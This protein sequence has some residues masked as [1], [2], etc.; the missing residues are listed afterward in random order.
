LILLGDVS[1]AVTLLRSRPQELFVR[2]RPL[3][4]SAAAALV[5]GL[6]GPAVAATS[7]PAAVRPAAGT[8]TSGLTLLALALAG[9]DVR[10]GSVALVSD[11]VSG[12]PAAKV[13]VTPVRADG[14]AYGEQTVT[15]ADSPAS[16]PSF[17]SSATLPAAL[18]TVASV[19]SPVFNVSSSTA[20]GASSKA[21]AAS[22]GSAKVLGLPVTLNGT[23]DVTS[24]VDGTNAVGTKTVSVKNLALPS[25]ADLLAALGLDLKAVPIKTLTDLLAGLGLTNTAVLT[26]QA[27]LNDAQAALG[28]S[29]NDAQAA[30]DQQQA[31]VDAAKAQLAAALTALDAAKVQSTQRQQALAAAQAKA[32]QADQ[33]KVAAQTAYDSANSSIATAAGGLPGS[34][35]FNAYVLAN[36]AAAATLQAATDTYNNSSA[37]AATAAA[38][39]ASAT[40]AAQAATAALNAAQAAVNTAQALVT[41]LSAVLTTLLNT[42]NSLLSQLASQINALL[43]AVTAVLDGTPLVSVDS[44]TVQTQALAKSASAGGQSSKVVGGEIQGVHVLGTDVLENVLGNS[45]INVLDLTGSTLSQVTSK[46]DALTGILSSVLSAVPGLS[47][48]A[49]K[50][51][52]LTKSTS[53]SIANGFGTAQNTVKALSVTIPAIT[54]PAALALPNAASLPAISGAPNLAGALGIAAVGDLTSQAMTLSVGTLS[55]RASF[56]PAGTTAPGA[57]GPP[58]ATTGLPAGVAVLGLLLLGF[59]LVLRRRLT[60]GV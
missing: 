10:V 38:A 42:L 41:S 1:A 4:A 13:V 12:S 54:L 53:T 23:V 2:I 59:G 16:I 29:L 25:I 34:A 46:L 51:Q 33:A 24:L 47:I 26:A 32:T 8:A 28:A 45:K 7:A 60:A 14:K 6:A 22:L 3:A 20:K 17:D 5:L 58:L 52:L 35:L 48:P 19:K 55:E 31:K 30:V 56:R 21:G 11:T 37:A 43:A 27:A 49:P 15:P 39:L 44:F 50:V 36:P 9:H 40:T 18:G 57:S